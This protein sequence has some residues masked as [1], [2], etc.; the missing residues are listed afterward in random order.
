MQSDAERILCFLKHFPLIIP[1]HNFSNIKPVFCPSQYFSRVYSNRYAT[2]WL[3]KPTQDN[4][5]KK[6]QSQKYGE[7]I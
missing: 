6:P 4:W 1:Y 7:T 5:R 2:I 3:V